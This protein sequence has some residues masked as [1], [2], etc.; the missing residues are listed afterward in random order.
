MLKTWM[1][2]AIGWSLHQVS[3]LSRKQAGDWALYLLA[4]PRYGRYTAAD[5]AFLAQADAQKTLYFDNHRTVVYEWQP[6]AAHQV[7]LLHGWES[8]AARWQPLIELLLAAGYGVIAPDAPAHGDSEG[9][10]LNMMRYS[11]YIRQL[12]DQWRPQTI[13]G[14]SLGGSASCLYCKDHPKHPLQQLVIMGVPSDFAAIVTY[15]GDVLGLSARM[16]ET[17]R[18]C[19]EQRFKKTYADLSVA[20][21]CQEIKV[22]TLVIHD[23][24]DLLSSSEDARTYARVLSQSELLITEGLGH[25]LQGKEVYQRILTYLATAEPSGISMEE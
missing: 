20:A 15:Y 22:P 25:S 5:A 21:F 7:L 2:K 1:P 14:H 6:Q 19:F 13:I 4:R 23:K 24:E 8:N 16:R 17:L 10:L 3:Y 9:T 18:M 11:R 12:V